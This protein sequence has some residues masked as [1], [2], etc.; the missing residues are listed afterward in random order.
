MRYKPE[1]KEATRGKIV[2]TAARLFRK[3]GY[4][5]VGIDAIM[6]ESSLTRGGFYKHFKSKSDLLAAVIGGAHD[7]IMRMRA[8]RGRTRAEL[9]REAQE[10]VDGYLERANLERIGKGCS[11]AALSADVARSN[12]AVR[13]AYAGK[14]EE[15]VAEFERGIA[16]RPDSRER[17]IVAIATCVGAVLLARGAGGTQ[18]SE[19]TLAACRD[20]VHRRLGM[21]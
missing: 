3:N 6:G 9:N 21:E 13:N 20:A 16:N 7:F 11:F 18:I 10:V 8:R 19:D 2:A 4:D 5:G 15:L 12:R 14:F 17:A 1:H